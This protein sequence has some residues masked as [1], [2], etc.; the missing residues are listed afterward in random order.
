MLRISLAS[1]L[2]SGCFVSGLEQQDIEV[3]IKAECKGPCN[4]EIHG[5]RADSDETQEVKRP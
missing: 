1:L 4:M 5:Q 3:R 2:L